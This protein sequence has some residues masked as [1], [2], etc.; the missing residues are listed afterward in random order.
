MPH[1]DS[2]TPLPLE[3]PAGK[4]KK[5]TKTKKTAAVDYLPAG[6][7][8]EAFSTIMRSDLKPLLFF[9]NGYVNEYSIL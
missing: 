5:I 1:A 9:F 4:R 6:Q 2:L 7:Q 3:G 8:W